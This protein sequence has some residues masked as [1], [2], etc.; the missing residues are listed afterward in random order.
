MSSL[1]PF[2]IGTSHNISRASSLVP[3]YSELHDQRKELLTVLRCVIQLL[4]PVTG[5]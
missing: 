4:I 3:Q 1:A 5:A 2:P